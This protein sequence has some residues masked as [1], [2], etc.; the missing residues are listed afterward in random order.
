MY[1][2]EGVWSR[3]LLSLHVTGVTMFSVIIDGI[4]TAIVFP[5][6][7]VWVRYW[8][9]GYLVGALTIGWLKM[10]KIFP[11]HCSTPGPL[12]AADY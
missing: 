4:L 8:H 12:S 2:L 6:G 1:H 5:T 10:R 11:K 7:I 3:L 9:I